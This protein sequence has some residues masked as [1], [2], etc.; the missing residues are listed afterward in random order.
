MNRK[1]ICGAKTN[2]STFFHFLVTV[3][4]SF[5]VRKT[6]L[7]IHGLSRSGTFLFLHP[8]L[9]SCSLFRVCVLDVLCEGVSLEGPECTAR[10]EDIAGGELSLLI[11]WTG[12]IKKYLFKSDK[13][14]HLPIYRRFHWVHVPVPKLTSGLCSGLCIGLVSGTGYKRS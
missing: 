13:H 10:A 12:C 3:V 14:F 5:Y 8:T 2:C 4:I 7:V 9:Y 6:L 1:C 11:M